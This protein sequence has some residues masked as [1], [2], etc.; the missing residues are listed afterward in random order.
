MKIN[1]TSL[2]LVFSSF[3]LLVYILKAK[4]GLDDGSPA[5]QSAV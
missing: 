4:G 3:D 1:R 5:M 2:P